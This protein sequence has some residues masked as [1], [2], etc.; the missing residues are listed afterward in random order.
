MV[1]HGEACKTVPY[2]ALKD[3]LQQFQGEGTLELN[4][5]SLFLMKYKIIQVCNLAQKHGF[6]NPQCGRV[7]SIDGVS[8]T[9]DTMQGGNRQPKIMIIE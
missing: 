4:Q 3:W 8:P 5:K 2:I 6:I 7:Y 1:L 9:L